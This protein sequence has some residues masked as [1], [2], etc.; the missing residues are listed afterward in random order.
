MQRHPPGLQHPHTTPGPRPSGPQE[1]LFQAQV[2]GD[3]LEG[4]S[5]MVQTGQAWISQ[6]VQAREV[7]YEYQGKG[8]PWDFLP[9]WGVRVGLGSEAVLAILPFLG[10]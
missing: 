7:L 5:P 1:L 8:I 4:Q 2:Q 6:G 3:H 9:A 10:S